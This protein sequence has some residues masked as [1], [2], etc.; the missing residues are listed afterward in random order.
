MLP[1]I[2]TWWGAEDQRLAGAGRVRPTLSPG[3][4]RPGFH[5]APWERGMPEDEILTEMRYVR[6]A[7]WSECRAGRIGQFAHALVLTAS[8]NL[9]LDEA[10]AG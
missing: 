1:I 7:G 8:G 10:A 2:A 3:R 4:A 5:I 6:W 9:A